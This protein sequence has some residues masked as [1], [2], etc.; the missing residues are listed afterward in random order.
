LALPFFAVTLFVSA[1]L[2]F[3]VQPMMGKMILPDLGGTP[4]VWNTCMVFFQMALLAGYAYTH[5]VSS[6][7]KLRAQLLVHGVLLL[8]PFLILLPGGPFNISWFQ[9]P[10]GGNPIPATLWLLTAVVGLPFF[11]V[12]TSAPLLQRW[13]ANTGHPAAKDPYFLYGASNLGSMLAL[14]AYPVLVEP[15][16][17]LTGFDRTTHEVIFA[18]QPWV[19]TF[20]YVL[21]V[22]LVLFCAA[23]VWNAPPGVQL[24]GAGAEAGSA[25]QPA[26][27]AAAQ[28]STA[29]KAAPPV[30]T[31]TA[32]STAIRKGSRQRGRGPHRPGQRPT[33]A[34]APPVH[35]PPVDLRRL[36][37]VTWP[38]RLRWILLAFVPSSLMLGITSYMSTDVAAIPFFWIVPLALY[39]LSFILVFLRWPVPWTGKPH[40]VMVLAQAFLILGYTVH[41]LIPGSNTRITEAITFSL[42]GFFFTAMMC[43]GELARDRPGTKH[44]TEFYLWLSVGG[45]LGGMFNGL[46]APLVFTSTLELPIAIA[47]G[48]MLRPY[49]SRLAVMDKPILILVAIGLGALVGFALQMGVI[50]WLL[51]VALGAVVG[52]MYE[53]RIRE[54][55]WTEGLLMGLFPG[56]GEWADAKG[57]EWRGQAPA[58]AA[59]PRPRGPASPPDYYVLSTALDILMPCLIV[60]FVWAVHAYM[61]TWS[62]WVLGLAKFLAFAPETALSFRQGANKLILYGLPVLLCFFFYARPLRLGLGVAACLLVT[63]FVQDRGENVLYA[64]R[65]YF[66]VLRVYRDERSGRN[67]PLSPEE[68]QLVAPKDWEEWSAQYPPYTYLMHGTTHHGLNY[69]APRGLRRL[70]TTYYHRKGPVGVIMERFNWFKE[71]EFKEQLDPAH[72]LKSLD[73]EGKLAPQDTYYADLR[74]PVSMIGVGPD[75]WTQMGTLW[76]EP[77]YAT[78]GLGTGTMASYAR[79]FHHMTYYEIDNTIRSFHLQNWPSNDNQPFFNYVDDARV[80]SRIKG[81]DPAKAYVEIIMGDARLSMTREPEQGNGWDPHRDHYYHALVVDAFSSDAIPVHLITKE[82][83]Q[84]YFKKLAPAGVLMVHTSNRHLELVWPVTDICADLKKNG[85]PEFENLAYRVGKDSGYRWRRDPKTGKLVLDPK[86]GQP[87]IVYS[88]DGHWS[89]TYGP[90]FRGLFGSEYVMIAR[91]EK[92]L[93]QNT[94][95]GEH[96]LVWLTPPPPGNRVWTDDFSNLVGVLRFL[97][98]RRG[99]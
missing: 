72:W 66:G 6:R 54:V 24:A 19:W 7:L 23:M 26:P 58:D 62:G 67:A 74:M 11:V 29:V 64:G 10:E 77:P 38:R 56:L 4:Q 48:V 76:S 5:V 55:G 37:D 94:P 22:G 83:I 17:R 31:S 27:A 21:L 49:Q 40:T 65:S 92:Y 57:R 80:R 39:L 18:S 53:P 8:V 88:G 3:L 15:T 28:P 84:L 96:G 34:A 93:P 61:E 89:P 30:A 2:L 45:M 14:L 47:L 70:A 50:V 95:E 99:E 36:E 59:A 44:L 86:T 41:L 73:A 43:H 25:T 12:S 52:A 98:P 85:G 81:A 9:P 68:A 42:L 46:V 97:H 32:R 63:A 75:V 71:V 78:I 69:Q 33:P 79:P 1:F 13:F 91:D 90:A 35:E 60:L 20:G 87:I 51:C 82:A 16:L